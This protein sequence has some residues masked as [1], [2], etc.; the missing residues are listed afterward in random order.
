MKCIA[1]IIDHKLV[2]HIDLKRIISYHIDIKINLLYYTL[3]YVKVSEFVKQQ[4]RLCEFNE[5]LIINSKLQ[6]SN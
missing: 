2:Y 3:Y 4:Q 5:K 1:V 6:Q